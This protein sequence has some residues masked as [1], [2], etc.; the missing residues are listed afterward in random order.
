M[1]N[2]SIIIPHKNIPNL[3]QRCLDSIPIRED[4]Q[5]IIV[6]DNSD[7]SK[8]NYE[9]FPGLERHNTDVIFDKSGKGA[10][11]ARN[12][13]IDHA[14]GKWLIFAD[15]DD[16]FNYCFRE[17]LDSCANKDADVVFFD[18]SSVDSNT[19]CNSNRSAYTHEMLKL[20]KIDKARA[21][22]QLR[23]YLGVPWCKIV[24]RQLVVDNNI[25]FDETPINNDTTF[26]YL[27]GFHAVKIE[28]DYRAGYCVTTRND[29]ISYTLNEEKTL[30]S[31]AVFARK[32]K[33]LLEHGIDINEGFINYHLNR[34]RQ[35]HNDR[36]Y[37]RGIDVLKSYG[38]DENLLLEP[39]WMP[40]ILDNDYSRYEAISS[41]C[42]ED[43]IVTAFRTKNI[44][45]KIIYSVLFLRRLSK[46]IIDI[47]C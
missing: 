31:I 32:R 27:V 11:R 12:I 1:I 41:S 40:R 39:T 45:Y 37:N 47:I 28:I 17:I 3:L 10:G 25:R 18:S 30:A 35:L 2:Y 6:D 22:F 20:S 33:F 26:S 29:S 38:F 8:V 16:F 23:Y 14:I 42:M 36:L 43:E 9:F 13:G 34:A 21:E 15:A 44:V 19:Y 4:L 24:K 46:R 7:S 5:V